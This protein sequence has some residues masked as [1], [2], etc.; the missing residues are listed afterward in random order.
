M[1]IGC[2]HPNVRYFRQ[3]LA[4]RPPSRDLLVPWVYA[5]G[6]LSYVLNE[7][8]KNTLAGVITRHADYDATVKRTLWRV[9]DGIECESP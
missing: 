6:S 9:K 5:S 3:R 8:W 4:V 1:R 2:I 7:A